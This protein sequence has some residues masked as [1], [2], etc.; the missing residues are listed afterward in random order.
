V[1]LLPCKGTVVHRTVSRHA[2]LRHDR[3]DPNNAG[4]DAK[5]EPDSDGYAHTYSDADSDADVNSN[6][7]SNSDTYAYPDT[8]ADSHSGCTNGDH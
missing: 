6:S 7:N 8:N 1:V 5:P 3:K 4:G 2:R